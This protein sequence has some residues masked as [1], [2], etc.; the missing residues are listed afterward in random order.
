MNR[1]A[2]ALALYLALVFVSGLLVGAFGYRLYETTREAPPSAENKRPT[3]EEYRSR[4]IALMDERLALSEAQMTELNAILDRTKQR[5]DALDQEYQEALRPR[6][7][8]ILDQQASEIMAILAPEQQAEYQ[9]IREERAKHRKSHS[10]SSHKPSDSRE[11]K[12]RD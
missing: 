11:P 4:F 10:P 7:R 2:G 9:K 5:F 12:K 3:P 8:A 1:S 6:K